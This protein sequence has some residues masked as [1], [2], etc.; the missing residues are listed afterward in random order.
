MSNKLK[1]P[2]DTQNKNC[3][4]RSTLKSISCERVYAHKIELVRLMLYFFI[5]IQDIYSNY[6]VVGQIWENSQKYI[7]LEFFFYLYSLVLYPPHTFDSHFYVHPW[8]SSN[9]FQ[10][11][12]Y[13]FAWNTCT[14]VLLFSSNTILFGYGENLNSCTNDGGQ[15]RGWKKTIFTT[16][17]HR[18]WT[19]NKSNPI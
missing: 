8:T 4:T 6:R 18:L 17:V 2:A 15:T 11:K 19:C 9:N 13:F 7:R 3:L 16:D 12:K 10:Q 5:M 14:Q 1:S